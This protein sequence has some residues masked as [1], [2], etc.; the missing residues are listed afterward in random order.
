MVVRLRGGRVVSSGGGRRR[1]GRRVKG[2]G[3]GS[4][5]QQL[6]DAIWPCGVAGSLKKTHRKEE[7]NVDN[8]LRITFVLFQR[9]YQITHTRSN[10]VD[11]VDLCNS[12]S[13]PPPR[14]TREPDRVKFGL[15]G[16]TTVRVIVGGNCGSSLRRKDSE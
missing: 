14:R 7:G 13:D 11:E 2:E 15:L 9:K 6:K 12:L 3:R 10:F 4:R 8:Q 1:R 5:V 16:L